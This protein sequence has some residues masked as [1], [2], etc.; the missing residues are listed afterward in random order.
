MWC[1][2]NNCYHYDKN[3]DKCTRIGKYEINKN[4]LGV[5]WMNKSEGE[6]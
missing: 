2:N 3:T 5:C 1:K 4:N 6:Y